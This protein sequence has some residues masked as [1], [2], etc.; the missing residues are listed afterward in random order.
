MDGLSNAERLNA[1]TGK[2]IE[3]VDQGSDHVIFVHFTDGSSIIVHGTVYF[4]Q[5]TPAEKG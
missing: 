5:A 3:R 1:L 4:G 2:V